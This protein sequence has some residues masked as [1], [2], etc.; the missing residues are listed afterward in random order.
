ML[1]PYKC[2][3]VLKKTLLPAV[4]GQHHE[5]SLLRPS[6][7]GPT[8]TFSSDLPEGLTLD[9]T[10]GMLEGTPEVEGH[11]TFEVQYYVSG[12]NCGKWTFELEVLPTLTP[13][14][15]KL[16]ANQT[17]RPTELDT[18]AGMAWGSVSR[19]T[20]APVIVF[21]PDPSTPYVDYLGIEP[22][23]GKTAGRQFIEDTLLAAFPVFSAG[24][25]QPVIADSIPTDGSPYIRVSP[26]NAGGPQGVRVLEEESYDVPQGKI[27][28]GFVRFPE[29]W[30]QDAPVGYDEITNQRTIVHELG[31]VFNGPHTWL[32]GPGFTQQ[33]MRRDRQPIAPYGTPLY[34]FDEDETFIYEIFY[35]LPVGTDMGELLDVG[36]FVELADVLPPP[37]I[38]SVHH[39]EY[40]ANTGS[41]F[42]DEDRDGEPFVP[43]E[44]VVIFGGH[45]ARFW[46]GAIQGP[47]NNWTDPVILVPGVATPVTELPT[48]WV[49][50]TDQRLEFNLPAG[51]VSGSIVV[52]NQWTL[53]GMTRNSDP[54]FID[55]D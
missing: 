55:V 32:P 37:A 29:D 5:Q 36:L 38:V 9:F 6:L 8:W 18:A 45:F 28:Y 35:Q 43:G 47:L 30:F 21:A 23:G 26:F 48:T 24:E 52:Q 39:M 25:L 42:P 41:W 50:R 34:W 44:R 11:H 51:A 16:L 1:K 14:Q 22:G 20:E 33:R 7:Y 10:T 4:L 19:F 17:L 54:F 12:T 27:L 15:R 13:Y 40:N 3:F 46:T 53:G 31:H 49:G 2:W